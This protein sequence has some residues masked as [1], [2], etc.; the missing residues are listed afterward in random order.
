MTETLNAKTNTPQ[1]ID[2]QLVA[3]GWINKYL[4]TYKMPDGSTYQYEAVSR[5]GPEAY[6]AALNRNANGDLRNPLTADA[7]CIVPFLPDG[8]VLLI[9]EFRYAVNGWVIAFPAGLLEPDETLRECV[10]REL[11][12]ETG[13]RVRTQ[14][15]NDEPLRALPQTGYSSVGMGEENVRVVFAQVEPI[16]GEEATPE[17]HEL[18]QPFILP[19][20]DV[21][22]FLDENPDLIGTRCQLLLESLR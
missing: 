3:E 11:R 2:V 7:V 22:R 16:D 18:I 12:E 4:L 19:R 9:R 14:C 6:Q 21:G 10:N 17:Q 20:A 8:S 1:L 13:Y 5:K 15:C